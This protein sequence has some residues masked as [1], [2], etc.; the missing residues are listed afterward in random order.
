MV[1]LG[2][3]SWN[4]ITV[5]MDKAQDSRIFLILVPVSTF[6]CLKHLGG[7]ISHLGSSRQ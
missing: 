7:N 6:R 5:N 4:V 1:G 2:N 3:V